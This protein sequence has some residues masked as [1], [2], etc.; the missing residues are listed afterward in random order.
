MSRI[1]RILKALI[2]GTEYSEPRMSRVEEILYSFL[3]D[4]IYTKDSGS[5]VEALLLA[6]KESGLYSDAVLSRVEEIL[7]S[8][9]ED[10]VYSKKPESRIEE[11]LLEW[12]T[13]GVK[14]I[15]YIES[16][17]TQ[18]IDC[19]FTPSS[20]NVKYV[21]TFADFVKP[22]QAY[23]WE[24]I[25]GGYISN[26]YSGVRPGGLTAGTN[27]YGGNLVVAIGSGEQ[28]T[29][30]NPPV[31][32]KHTYA[33]TIDGNYVTLDADGEEYT[34]TFSGSIAC[35]VAVCA[36]AGD[37][38]LSQFGKVK[39]YAFQIYENDILVRDFVPALKDGE[40]GL[41]DKVSKTF[42]GNDGTGEFLYQER[43][44][45]YLTADSKLYITPLNEVYKIKRR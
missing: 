22:S 40:A 18:A 5:R 11:L 21:C 6:L 8:K 41:Y 20:S 26:A 7:L 23:T 33:V 2:N 34:T 38:G 14:I 4:T 17:G 3:I 30:L 9:L 29:T 43:I 1:E 28:F 25:Y 27:S 32:G 37:N 36:A 10:S 39:I 31:D 16:T 45:V 35:P 15:E 42:F 13:S 19:G 44:P 12:E 24:Y